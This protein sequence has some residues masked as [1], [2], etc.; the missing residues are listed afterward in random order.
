MLNDPQCLPDC[1]GAL[2]EDEQF[3]ALVVPVVYTGPASANWIPTYAELARTSGKPVCL[4]WLAEW[5]EGAGTREAEQEFLTPLFRS[6]DRCF[7]TI[8]AWQRRAGHGQ[9]PRT[10]PAPTGAETRAR[11]AALI[12]AAPA[13]TLTEREAKAVLALYGVPVV[14]ERLTH[15]ADEAAEAAAALGYPVAVKIESADLPHKTEAGVI[16]LGLRTEAELREG[17]AAVMAN[18]ARVSPPPR[19]AGV[20][21]QPMA[22]PGVEVLIGG[23]VDPLFGPLVVVGLGGILV[24]LLQDRAVGLAPLAP[25]EARAMLGRLK[26]A[27]A[28]RG[29]R[30]SAP[31]DLDRLAGIVSR[32]SVFIADHAGSVVELDVNPLICAGKDIVA[33]DALIVRRRET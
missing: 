27:A 1:A 21:V 32:V 17:Y 15:S 7:A 23:R 4:V 18:A 33:V 8:A 29:F 16:R 5:M 9:A 28:L 24:E 2:L 25:E 11:A 22:P 3:G 31:V 20:L 6:M 14:G 13:A 26:G 19:I 12:A 10:F 30:G